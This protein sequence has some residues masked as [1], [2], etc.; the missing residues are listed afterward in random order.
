MCVRVR[1]R[2]RV[3]VCWGLCICLSA[4]SIL[5]MCMRPGRALQPQVYSQEVAAGFLSLNLMSITSSPGPATSPLRPTHIS[6]TTS[7]EGGED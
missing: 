1:V 3:R 2:V 5:G 4:F 6:R 7:Y